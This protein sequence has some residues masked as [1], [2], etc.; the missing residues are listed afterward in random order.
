[1]PW[2]E[3]LKFPRGYQMGTHKMFLP[4]NLKNH[5]GIVSFV[6]DGMNSDDLGM[7][8][9]EDY[10]IAVRTGYHCA[11]YIHKYLH[12]E[13]TLGTVRIGVSQ[14]TTEDDVDQLIEA[15]EELKE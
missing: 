7:I 4:S 6:F 11:P 8:L 9:D 12:D 15:L 10:D 14:F 2:L 5:V 1:M 3:D 13:S